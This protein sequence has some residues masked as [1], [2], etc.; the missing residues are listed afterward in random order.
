MRKKTTVAPSATNPIS[1]FLNQLPRSSS[2]LGA[3][4]S[5]NQGKQEFSIEYIENGKLHRAH[6]SFAVSS[7]VSANI[8]VVSTGMKG[9]IV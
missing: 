1:G 6:C 5:R 7:S 4:M 9:G 8:E 3:K 2:I